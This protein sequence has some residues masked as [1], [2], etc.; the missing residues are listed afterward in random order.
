M[1]LRSTVFGA[2]MPIFF[3]SVRVVWPSAELVSGARDG[4]L[5]ITGFASL[6]GSVL[7]AASSFSSCFLTTL[8]PTPPRAGRRS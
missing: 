2:C 3:M 5:G 4:L 1:W 6:T 8:S 7:Q